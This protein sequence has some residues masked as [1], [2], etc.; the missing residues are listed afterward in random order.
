MVKKKVVS[1]YLGREPD[2][3]PVTERRAQYLSGISGDRCPEDHRQEDRRCSQIAEVENRLEASPVP[4]HL[5][6]GGQKESGH[7]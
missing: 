7:R 1:K 2:Q 6:P 5:R 3:L 4:A